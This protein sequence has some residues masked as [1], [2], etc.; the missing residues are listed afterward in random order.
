MHRF[1]FVQ[2]YERIDQNLSVYTLYIM[3]LK[4]VSMELNQYAMP[5]LRGLSRHTK[6]GPI[7]HQL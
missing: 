4:L 1:I 2:S 6:K 5:C 3:V 7:I